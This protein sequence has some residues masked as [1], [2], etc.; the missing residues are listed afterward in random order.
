MR[1]YAALGDTT[2]IGWERSRRHF[3]QLQAT[4]PEIYWPTTTA[5]PLF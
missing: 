5:A 2:S 1:D 4:D 3:A